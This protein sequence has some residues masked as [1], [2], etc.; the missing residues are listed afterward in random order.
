LHNAAV[1]GRALTLLFLLGLALPQ[2]APAGHFLGTRG[3]DSIAG[4][5][6]P[7]RIHLRAGADLGFGLGGADR[8]RGGAGSDRLRGGPGA[9]LLRGGAGADF[10]HG[11]PR[12][13]RLHGGRGPDTIQARDG[14]ADAV[15]AGPGHDLCLLDRGEA[16]RARGCET[17]LPPPGGAPASQALGTWE[18]TRFDTCPAVLHDTFAVI[19]ADGKRYPAWH[20]PRVMDPL[21]GRPCTFGHEHGRNPAGSDLHAWVSRHLAPGGHARPGGL[22]FGTAAEALD[23]YAVANPGVAP[24][25]E[26]HVGHKV[27][28]ENDVRLPGKTGPD[29]APVSCDFLTKV[30]QGSHSADALGN[31]LHEVVYA[32]GCSD[33][34]RLLATTMVAFGAPNQFLRSCDGTAVAA[35]TA[36]S[37]PAGAGARL[38]P[39]RS[40]VEEHVLVGA[41]QR[42]R[43]ARGLYESWL[44]RSRLTTPGGRALASFDLRFG[45]LNPSRYAD[46]GAPGGLG[47]AIDACFEVESNGDRARGGYC[48]AA[49]AYGPLPFDSPR[50]GFDGSR[51]EVTVER[52]ELANAG[53]PG[54]WWTDPFGGGASPRPFP[55]ALCQLVS[56]PGT[57]PPFPLRPL[58][59]GRHR[60]Y[61]AGGVHAPN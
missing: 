35:G 36:H 5:A 18:P 13:D 14:G 32:T 46:P 7:D 34:T 41:G 60:D 11:G 49:A 43:Y 57:R 61:G 30:H 50:S 28:W 24:R 48:E 3:T 15:R 21:S 25:H 22:P 54:R 29:G 58:S 8:L 26:D 17:I 2:T 10:L 42:S 23:A 4:S 40:C 33:G 6:G 53:G 44:A 45:V 56:G 16:A 19:G 37:F 12:R 52:T 59:F 1:T 9:D 51:R 27:E 55:G 47:R 20:P 38:I 39:D 31:N